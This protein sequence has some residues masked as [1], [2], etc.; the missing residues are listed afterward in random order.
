MRYL[1]VALLAGCSAQ[2]YWTKDA[3]IIPAEYLAVAEHPCN[4][5]WRGCFNRP[6]QGVELVSGPAT[7]LC[8]LRHEVAHILGWRHPLNMAFV[9]DCGPETL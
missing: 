7:F 5:N 8:R 9:L 4:E 6:Q 3:P 2:P 1:L